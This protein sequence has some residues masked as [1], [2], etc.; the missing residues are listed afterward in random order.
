MPK[1]RSVAVWMACASACAALASGSIACG[2]DTTSSASSSV[3]ASGGPSSDSRDSDSGGG[4]DD[5]G[6]T[7]SY[8]CTLILGVSATGEWIDEGGFFDLVDGTRFEART[9]AHEFI[10]TWPS[11]TMVWAQPFNPAGPAPQP[12]GP[13]HA[14]AESA[15]A[16]DRVL[17]VAY[18]D[19]KNTTYQGQPGWET[20]LEQDIAAIRAQYPSTTRIEL[21]TMVRG[22]LMQGGTTYPGGYNCD[23]ALEEDIVAPYVDQAIAAE[24]TKHPAL[25]FAGPKFYVGDCSWWTPSGAGRG[26]HFVPQG[27]PALEAEKIADYYRAGICTAPWCMP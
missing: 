5:G 23:K 18:T 7:A 16:P 14:C 26:P 12:G 21:L 20:A 15:S 24:A 2:N 10:E 6:G 3:D 27:Q 25:V 1:P 9:K 4:G 22:P 8:T 19:P 17:L 13:P 11:D